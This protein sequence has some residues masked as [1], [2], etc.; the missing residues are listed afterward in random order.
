MGLGF[1]S[2][3][4]FCDTDGTKVTEHLAISSYICDKYK[5]ELN[6]RNLKERAT[7]EM[8]AGVLF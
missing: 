8:L 4:Y 5:P 3:P 2:L 6:G 1:A 7:I